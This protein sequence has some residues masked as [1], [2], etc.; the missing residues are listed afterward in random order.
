VPL[1]LLTY[2]LYFIVNCHAVISTL[3]NL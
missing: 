1:V 3:Q 2:E